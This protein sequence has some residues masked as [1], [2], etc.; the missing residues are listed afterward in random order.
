MKKVFLIAISLFIIGCSSVTKNNRQAAELQSVNDLRSDVD[1]AYKKMQRLH[2]NLYWY[3]S[4][5]DLDYKFDSLKTTITKPMNSF[6]F[7]KKISPVIASVRQGHMSVFPLT[8]QPTE[9]EAKALTSKGVGPFSQFEFD[10]INDKMYVT[11]NKSYNKSIKP[12]TE[13]VAINNVNPVELFRTYDTWFASDGFNKTFKTFKLTKT[14]PAYYTYEFGIQDSIVYNFKFNDSVKVVSIKRGIVDTIKPVKP[15]PKKK[16]TAVEKKAQKNKSK[17]ENRKK[18]IY[19]YNPTYKNYNR[20]LTFKEADSSIAVMKI[21]GFSMGN[22]YTFYSESFKKIK[23]NKSK[24]LIIDLRD[25]PGGRLD[26]IANLYSYLS[27]STFVFT[28]KS[29]VATRTS[30]L[31]AN[32]FGGGSIPVKAVKALVSPLYFGY[33]FL[34]VK[35]ANGKYYYGTYD[36]K[37]Q[38]TSPDAFKGKIYVLINGGSFSASCIL[39]SNLKGAKRAYFVGQET[40]G[41][42]NGTVAGRMPVVKLPHSKVGI[43]MGLMFIAP[44]QKT[45]IEGRGIF[46]DKEIVPTLQDKLA[47]N[48][49]EMNWIMED[50]KSNGTKNVE[51][52]S[53]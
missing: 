18:D 29:E 46:P 11:K 26:E 16:L 9:M 32:Y 25:N 49:P 42:Y 38:K 53:N 43:K 17:A 52:A 28:D 33:T 6:D 23:A 35:K 2:P 24:T 40:G 51:T 14:F 20:N 41:A 39:S 3:I 36:N 50:I 7:F 8:K 4:K 21:R 45:D 15:E 22:P 37:P 31:H 30:L 12:G 34:K 48:D 19:G 1:Y 10:I 27:D 44:H 5:K 13:V 47:E